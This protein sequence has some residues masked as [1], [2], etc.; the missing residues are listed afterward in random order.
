MHQS[1]RRTEDFVNAVGMLCPHSQDVT[2]LAVMEL[3]VNGGESGLDATTFL[4]DPQLLSVPTLEDAGREVPRMVME[5]SALVGLADVVQEPLRIRT[6]AL[7][8][9]PTEV[10]LSVDD[11]VPLR[12]KE[13]K[14]SVDCSLKKVHD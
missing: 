5:R 11:D 8:V 3:V 4:P 9:P 13:I 2:R 10:K 14:Y 12:K 1:I 7:E 6:S